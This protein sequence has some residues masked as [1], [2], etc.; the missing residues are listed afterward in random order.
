MQTRPADNWT[1]QYFLAALGYGG[2]AVTFFI[3][4]YMWVPHPGQPVPVFEDIAAAWSK[5]NPAQQG[6][7]VVAMAAIALLSL[8]HYRS[9]I[10]NLTRFAA[11][12]RTHA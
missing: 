12:K 3:W 9:L 10:W 11:F 7:I 8:L 5:G 4:L 2:L 1:P 6:M